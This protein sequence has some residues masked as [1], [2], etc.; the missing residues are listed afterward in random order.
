[1]AVIPRGATVTLLGRNTATTWAKIAL[2]NGAQGWVN[3]SYL[4]TTY[5]LASLP[6]AE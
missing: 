2:A 5:P 6:V 1:V 4:S 3:A